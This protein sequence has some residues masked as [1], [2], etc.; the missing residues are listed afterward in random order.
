MKIICLCD[1]TQ[2]ILLQICIRFGYTFWLNIAAQK[3]NDSE[4]DVST[5]LRK[6]TLHDVTIQKTASDLTNWNKLTRQ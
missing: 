2:C 1:F 5:L 3:N 4:D 6:A